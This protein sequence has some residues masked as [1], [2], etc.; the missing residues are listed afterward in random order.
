MRPPPRPGLYRQLS[1]ETFCPVTHIGKAIASSC[2]F[3]FES[4]A[5]ITDLQLQPLLRQTKRYSGLASARIFG[6]I[7]QTLFNDQVK[8]PPLFHIQLPAGQS[9]IELE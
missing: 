4:P 7:V 6:D 9:F 5:I 2:R 1:M 3:R 8:M